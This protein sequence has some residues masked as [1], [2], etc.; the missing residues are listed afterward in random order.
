MKISV[1]GNRDG[2]SPHSE[3]RSVRLEG[4]ASEGWER[5]TAEVVVG[6]VARGTPHRFP[7][8]TAE[9][10][11]PLGEGDEGRRGAVI[12]VR[13]GPPR[14]SGPAHHERL[15]APRAEDG[16]GGVGG[17]RERG[18]ADALGRRAG[19]GWQVAPGVIMALGPGRGRRDGGDWIPAEDAGMTE[20]EEDGRV[21]DAAPTRDRDAGGRG[22]CRIPGGWFDTALRRTSARLTTNG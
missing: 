21:S 4:I 9:S 5:R 20:K 7:P 2:K 16:R 6:L 12:V 11:S 8:G 15:G 18:G 3:A 17:G 1:L 13:H 19:T 10:A 14:D 22:G